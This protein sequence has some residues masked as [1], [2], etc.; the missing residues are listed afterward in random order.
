MD[1]SPNPFISTSPPLITD[2]LH[3]FTKFSETGFSL[4][5]YDKWCAFRPG[6][7]KRKPKSPTKPSIFVNDEDEEEGNSPPPFTS[8]KKKTSRSHNSS[9]RRQRISSGSSSS[10][11][12][13]GQWRSKERKLKRSSRALESP[14]PNKTTSDKFTV[15]VN[16]YRSAMK[17]V[18]SSAR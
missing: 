1:R 12:G 11:E 14:S 16:D 17:G 3:S 18:G 4:D 13:I 15:A 5:S 6:K 2:K 7:P 9:S 8:K 10:D